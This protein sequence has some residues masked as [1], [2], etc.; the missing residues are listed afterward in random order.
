MS[1]RKLVVTWLIAP[2]EN[3]L[4]QVPRALVASCLAAAVDLGI[5]ILL[6][7]LAG[8]HPLAAA[9]VSYLLGGV[10]QYYLCAVWV[11]P[12]AP[13]KVATGFAAFT[14]LSLV[15][16]GITWVTM[17]LLNDL[18]YVNYALAKIAALVLAFAWNFLSR[19]YLLFK[20][21]V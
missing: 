16:L 12:A 17:A 1:T 10:L 4:L 14:L 11:F 21:S 19:K 8:W 5:L 18:L 9:T 2:V 3:T 20:S 13:E 15:G 6:V 7:E